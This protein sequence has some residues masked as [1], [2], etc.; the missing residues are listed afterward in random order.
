MGAKY[1]FMVQNIKTQSLVYFSASQCG[2][3]KND[4]LKSEVCTAPLDEYNMQK[5]TSVTAD[6]LYQCD[7]C[8]YSLSHNYKLKRQNLKKTSRTS[9]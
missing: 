1:D 4:L 9:S 6:K 7:K 8:P 5:D 3:I 2:F